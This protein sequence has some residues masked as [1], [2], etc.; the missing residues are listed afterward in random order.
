MYHSLP[1]LAALALGLTTLACGGAPR[2]DLDSTFAQIQDE[3][4]RIEH[5][6]ARGAATDDCETRIAQC[7]ELCDAVSSL[8]SVARESEDRDALLRCERAEPRC[9]ACRADSE[10][11]GTP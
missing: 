1:I 11:G 5:A 8:C 3:E 7:A 6:A 2:A 10:C 9:A 4:A